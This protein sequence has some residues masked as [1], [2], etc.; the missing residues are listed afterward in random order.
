MRHIYVYDRGSQFDLLRTVPGSYLWVSPLPY[1]ELARHELVQK[2]CKEA[3]VNRDVAVWRAVDG[4][5]Y[6]ARRFLEQLK[7]GVAATFPPQE[8]V[9]TPSN[10]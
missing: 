10:T 4:L 6:P 3:G 2:P 7:A 8:P 1:Q 5:G 9:S